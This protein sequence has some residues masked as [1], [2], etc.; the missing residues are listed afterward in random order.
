MAELLAPEFH[1]LPAPELADQRAFRAWLRREEGGYRAIYLEPPLYSA[2]TRR[3]RVIRQS[4]RN[5]A[6][7]RAT[8]ERSLHA[9]A[10]SARAYG[11]VGV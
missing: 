4:R 7:R 5:F 9:E 10:G 2:Y 1:P 6:R 11:I 3:E 8:I